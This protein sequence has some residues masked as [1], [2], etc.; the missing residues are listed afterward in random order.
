MPRGYKPIMTALSLR[1]ATPDDMMT[2]FTWRNDAVTR[3]MSIDTAPVELSSHEVWYR[4]ALSRSSCLIYIVEQGDTADKVA[5][6]RF[7]TDSDKK[8]SNISINLNPQHR[9]RGLGQQCLDEGIKL[10]KAAVPSCERILAH[11]KAS[12]VGSQK[13]FVRAGFVECASSLQHCQNNET[14][15]SLLEYEYRL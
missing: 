7:E 3:E 15:N 5:M 10:F 2:L 13:S 8:Q 4:D 1:L 6:L 9:G 12:N 14:A 11:I